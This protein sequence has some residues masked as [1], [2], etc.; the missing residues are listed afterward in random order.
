M[1]NTNISG[2]PLLSSPFSMR[3]GRFAITI[4]SAVLLGQVLQLA[5][6]SKMGQVNE[7]KAQ[8][9]DHTIRALMKY[10]LVD[11]G[12]RFEALSC[13]QKAICYRYRVSQ[14]MY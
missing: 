5:A 8:Q 1:Q 13:E 6:D 11:C 3:S 7:Q 2:S 4:Q 12:E 9:L 14:P 10:A